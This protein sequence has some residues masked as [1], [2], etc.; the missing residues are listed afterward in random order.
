MGEGKN[1]ERVEWDILSLMAYNEDN[2][3]NKLEGS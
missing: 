2:T 3:K 1:C